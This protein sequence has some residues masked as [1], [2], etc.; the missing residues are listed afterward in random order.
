MT[1]AMLPNSFRGSNSGKQSYVTSLDVLGSLVRDKAGPED[2]P[3]AD[4]ALT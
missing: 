2:L 3:W 4:A 1:V